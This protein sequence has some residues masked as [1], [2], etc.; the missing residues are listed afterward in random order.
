MVVSIVLLAVLLGLA[1]LLALLLVF[2]HPRVRPLRERL[3]ETLAERDSARV[4]LAQHQQ[5]VSVMREALARAQ[6]QLEAA[7]EGLDKQRETFRALAAEALQSNNAQFLSLA[8]A[9]LET[10][11]EQAKGA[12]AEKEQAVEGLVKP[13]RESLERVNVQAQE[14]EKARQL[15]YGGLAEQV[16]ALLETN[17]GLRAETGNLVRALRQPQER[18]AWGE[19]QLR[20]VLDAAGLR[21]GLDYVEQPVSPDGRQRP[22]V[23]VKLPDGGSIVIDA[24]APL[25]AFLRGYE[26][27]GEDERKAAVAEHIRLVKT[28]IAALSAK[29]YW[30][31]FS[32]APEFVVMFL[33]GEA[34]FIAAL[35]QAPDLIQQ[36]VEQRVI[37][38]SP[39]TLIALL[40]AV[41][42]GWRQ[43]KL[44]EQAQQIGALGTALYERLTTMAEHLARVGE[45]IGEAKNAYNSTIGSLERNVLPA[46]RRFPELGI[47][48]AREMP[49]L[50]SIDGEVREIQAK[51]LRRAGAKAK[52]ELTE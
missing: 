34:F 45:K 18:G 40:R 21:A 15:A 12:F 51:E 8:R 23:V 39:I 31:Q 28:H 35:E 46:A 13:I 33:P 19:L 32:P 16:R 3:E 36:T 43:K 7:H 44:E 24:K 38:A 20:N 29:E 9:S 5:Q 10:Y 17:Q 47:A 26:A 41:A 30:S 49:E 42:Y 2:W 50:I 25:E 27:K 11:Q 1:V 48:A 37:L 52:V 6:T 22:D 14:L 4:E